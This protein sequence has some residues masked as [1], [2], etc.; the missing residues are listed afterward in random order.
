MYLCTQRRYS[1][2]PDVTASRLVAGRE[3]DH[4]IPATAEAL[5]PTL[6]AAPE[7]Q[8]ANFL[9]SILAPPPR[10]PLAAGL[11]SPALSF[12]PTALFPSLLPFP[13]GCDS[14]TV[15]DDG[16]GLL[17]ILM[18]YAIGFPSSHPSLSSTTPPSSLQS[19]TRHFAGS[20]GLLVLSSLDRRRFSTHWHPCRRRLPSFFFCCRGFPWFFFGH[21][22]NEKSSRMAGL[23]GDIDRNSGALRPLVPDWTTW[24]PLT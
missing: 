3:R 14:G 6:S 1:V 11:P 19:H 7:Q 2:V 10:C 16:I 12:S 8:Q 9:S 20:G 23:T 13:C 5:Y 15:K 17:E 4:G 21:R 24:T 18:R 22:S